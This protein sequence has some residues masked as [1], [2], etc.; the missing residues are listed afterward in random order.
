ML[1]RDK[2]IYLQ[3]LWLNAK[4]L[5]ELLTAAGLP[6]VPGETPIIPVMV[7]SADLT[8]EFAGKLAEQGILVSGIR[9]P[10]VP[11]GESRLRVTVTAAHS[12]EQ[13]EKAAEAI[14]KTWRELKGKKAGK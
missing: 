12:T 6:V 14:I 9:P 7:G 11:Q 5:R 13:L 1:Q 8:S 3:K 2:E 10:T 4:L